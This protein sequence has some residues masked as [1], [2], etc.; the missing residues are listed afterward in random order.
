MELKY[1]YTKQDMK[2]TAP[3][4]YPKGWKGCPPVSAKIPLCSRFQLQAAFF[5]ISNGNGTLPQ[6][7]LNI[8]R[9]DWLISTVGFHR[10]KHWP[11]GVDWSIFFLP[12]SWTGRYPYPCTIFGLDLGSITAWWQRPHRSRR[13]RIQE[14]G[15]V[16]RLLW[17]TAAVYIRYNY[18]I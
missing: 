11:K 7:I 14:A 17:C 3:S 8:G 4:L 15:F 5:R 6:S 18:I 13:L 10:K 12:G 2:S 16:G 1:L 9:Q